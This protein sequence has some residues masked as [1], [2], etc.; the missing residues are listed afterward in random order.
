MRQLKFDHDSDIKG[1][2]KYN[3]IKLKVADSTG[4]TLLVILRIYLRNSHLSFG[5]RYD[6]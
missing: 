2:Q 1:F 4:F 6:D 3:K 5:N